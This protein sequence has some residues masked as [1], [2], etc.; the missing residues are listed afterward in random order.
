MSGAQFTLATAEDGFFVTVGE[1]VTV[2][3][4]YSDAV[5]E[6]QEEVAT[7]TESFL[8]EVV[9]DTD[10]GEDVAVTLEQVSWQQV[11]QDMAKAGEGDGV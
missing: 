8:A 3:E 11:I 7:D 4:E 1:D 9:I 6:I 10:G 5:V 2:Y